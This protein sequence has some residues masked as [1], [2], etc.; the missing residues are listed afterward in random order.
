M[1]LKESEEL[2]NYLAL[3]LLRNYQ[4]FFVRERHEL[5]D[6]NAGKMHEHSTLASPLTREANLKIAIVFPG[7]TFSV[8]SL[9][10]HLEH[11]SFIPRK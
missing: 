1:W 11:K 10:C 3:S 7:G 8:S 4:F 6:S 5:G 9:S 2:T